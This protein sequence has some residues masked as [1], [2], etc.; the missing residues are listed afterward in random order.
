LLIVITIIG[1]LGALAYPAIKSAL[2]AA[3]A[4]QAVSGIRQSGMILL[5]SSTESNNEVQLMFSGSMASVDEYTLYDIVKDYTKVDGDELSKIIRTPAYHDSGGKWFV[6]AVN[7][8]GPWVEEQIQS[9]DSNPKVQKLQLN[10]LEN[11]SNFPLL[12]DSSNEDG[13][14]R[15]SFGNDYDRGYRFAMRYNKKGPIFFL[16][17]SVQMVGADKMHLYGIEEGFVF[18]RGSKTDPDAVT[19]NP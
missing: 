8:D 19:S 1:L 5:A 13:S 14:P 17:G 11:H 18:N 15:S 12:A 9:G 10:R 7:R 2:N 16:D 6:W 3:K 4:A